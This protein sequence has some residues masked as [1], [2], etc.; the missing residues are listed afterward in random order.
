AKAG[1]PALMT[2][3]GDDLVQGGTAAGRRELA[4]YTAHRYHTPYDNFNPQW[5]FRGVVED[6]QAL[7]AVGRELAGS[8]AWPQWYQDSEFH[9]QRK[10]APAKTQE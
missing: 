1:V 2:G 6:A 9:A 3:T 5:D 8:N 4:D 10:S 7:Y